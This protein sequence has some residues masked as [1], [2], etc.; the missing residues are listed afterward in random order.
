MSLKEKIEA[1]K[2]ASAQKIPPEAREVMGNAIAAL[3]NS[4]ILDSVLKTGDSAPPF[5]LQNA[6]GV[7]VNSADIL[8]KGPMVL[9]FY[10]GAW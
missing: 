1:L 3:K 9:A 4:G 7:A 2:A 6:E 5:V 8:K 10:R